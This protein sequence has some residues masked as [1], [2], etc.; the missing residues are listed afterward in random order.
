MNTCKTAIIV[1]SLSLVAC[2]SDQVN[3]KPESIFRLLDN[4]QIGLDFENKVVDQDNFN[5]LTYRNYYNG[6]GVAVG[7][8]NNDGLADLFFTANMGPNQ[9]YLNKGNLTFENISKRAGIE[10]KMKWSTGVTMADVNGDGYLDI[11]VCNS[12]D[13]EGKEKENELFIN[14]GDLSFDEK[15]MEYGL[16]DS[17]FS[18]HASFFDMDRDGDLDMY[19]LNNSFKDPSRIDFRNVRNER[20]TEGGDKLFRNDNNRFVDISE[21]A[22]IYGSKIG[23][24][25]GISVS[26]IDGDYLPD[27]Y[28]SNDFWERDYLYINRGDGTFS[29]E[30][31]D[32]IPMTSTAS[33]GAD[34]A[35]IDNNGSFDIFSTDMLP[36][37]SR[38]LKTTTI[39]NDYKLEDLKYRNDYHFQATQNCLQLNDGTGHFQEIAN[40]LGVAAT[41]WSWA[42]L[43]FDFDNDG[44]KDIYVSNGVY[45]DITDMD[46]SDF[47]EDNDQVKKIVEKK[48]RFDFRDFLELLPSSPLVNYA[49]LNSGHLAFSNRAIELGLGQKS[50]SNGSAYGDLD[51][52]GD[53]DLIVNNINMP[54]FIYENQTDQLNDFG[55]LRI[56]FKGK[57]GNTFGIGAQIDIVT[58]HGQYYFQNY[59]SRG[60]Q[61][62]TEPVLTV[63]LGESKSIHSVRVVWPSGLEEVLKEVPINSELVLNEESAVDLVK[64]NDI[65]QKPLISHLSP[66]AAAR[67]KENLFN[68]FDNESLALHMLSTEG[69]ELLTD[70]I[71]GNGTTDM[72]LLGAAGD[73]DKVLL[74]NDQNQLVLSYQPE[75][76]N[77]SIFESTCGILY[78]LDGDGDQDLIIGSGGNDMTKGIESVRLR[79]YINDGLGNFTKNNIITLPVAGHL[80]CISA[81][82]LGSQRALFFGARSVPG[83]YGLT[84]RNFL[85]LEQ[86]LGFWRD[87]TTQ[88]LGQLGMITDAQSA[89]IDNDGDQD[90]LV[91]GEWMPITIFENNGSRLALK[92]TVSNSSGLWQSIN[93]GDIDNDGDVD[94]ILGNWGTNSKL[95]ASQAKPLTMFV[96][97]F[98]KNGK[99]ENILLWY[100]PEDETPSLF[101]AKRDLTG[102]L[103]SLKK[104]ILKNKDYSVSR[105]EELFDKNIIDQSLRLQVT[106]L[107]SSI[108]INHG[109]FSLDLDP[110]P[111]EAQRSVIFAADLIDL[112]KDKILDLIIGGNLYGLKP[113]IGRMDS[114]NGLVL[115]G[116]GTGSFSALSKEISGLYTKGE[117][118]DIKSISTRSGVSILAIARN[119][120]QLD[121]Y[122]IND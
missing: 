26:D 100:A 68:D 49:Y 55:N 12:G 107:R 39:F 96:N 56:K 94:F 103:P 16:N 20:D 87:I 6:G 104:K 120:N 105:F 101:A 35:D 58:D 30:L 78:D 27:M 22:G 28:I 63:G 57:G 21:E 9:L 65:D 115:L 89:D 8:I 38:R 7:D 62:S 43:I 88:D 5:V 119:N 50:F 110:L 109:N 71:D 37:T 82:Q 91:V 66:F 116:D 48:G 2:N 51:N 95:Q 32:R 67:H 72:I 112:N 19:L 113:E 106:E 75:I 3:L 42:A 40:Q 108:L 29:E 114:S 73:P 1:M 93:T 60:F 18:T 17:G 53:L 77:D 10:G 15:A 33:M 47:L 14:K 59:Q 44:N 31:T 52:D 74:Q 69:P 80:S 84:P 4:N 46:F 61:S 45:H 98:D 99:P 83:N 24:G 122:R 34:I 79:S 90:L 86:S 11:Y 118:R 102:Q 64:S 121:L 117:I 13:V 92:G 85:L 111:D 70:D 81:I 97:D 23:F 76:E 41:D 54:A 25:L 36:A